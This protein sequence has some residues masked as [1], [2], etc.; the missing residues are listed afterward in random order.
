MSKCSDQY[1]MFGFRLVIFYRYGQYFSSSHFCIRFAF[2]NPQGLLYR[3][4]NH[5]RGLRSYRG[6]P[7]RDISTLKYDYC[8]PPLLKK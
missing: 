3:S 4:T 8:Q 5:G 7:D 1:L 6:W 2:P